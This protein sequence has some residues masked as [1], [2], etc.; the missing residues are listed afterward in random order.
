[1]NLSSHRCVW[2]IS[3][4]V[5]Q[6]LKQALFTHS[7]PV[8]ASQHYSCHSQVTLHHHSIGSTLLQGTVNHKEWE[9]RSKQS[10]RMSVI[11]YSHLLIQNRSPTGFVYSHRAT[12]NEAA[13]KQTRK[14]GGIVQQCISVSCWGQQTGGRSDR[15][16]ETC[17]RHRDKDRQHGDVSP[18]S[19]H[20]AKSWTQ[21]TG[22]CTR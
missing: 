6:I 17:C 18:T 12:F 2:I 5:T 10:G 8:C 1:M 19:Q 22:F 21:E 9:Q 20:F 3:D 7:F 4:S 11:Y 16:W 13:W 15:K 14:V